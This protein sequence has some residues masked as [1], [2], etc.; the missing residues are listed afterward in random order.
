MAY[1]CS[2]IGTTPP[3]IHPRDFSVRQVFCFFFE[4]MNQLFLCRIPGPAEDPLFLVYRTL[5]RPNQIV[6]QDCSVA[7]L[8]L[9]SNM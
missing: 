4:S 1:F 7:I 6:V 5:D 8:P 3:I 2:E 9:G